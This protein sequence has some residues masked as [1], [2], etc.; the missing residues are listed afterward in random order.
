MREHLNEEGVIQ[1]LLKSFVDGQWRF[2]VPV[3]WDQYPISSAGNRSGLATPYAVYSGGNSPYVTDAY[4][5]ELLA[6][7]AGARPRHRR[8][9]ALGA[10]GKPEAVLRAIRRYLA[11]TAN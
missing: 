2:N 11:D 6:V 10:C 3:L 7:P 8:R 4:R 1:F 9:R 5:D